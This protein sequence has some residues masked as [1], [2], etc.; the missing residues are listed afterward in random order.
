[1]SYLEVAEVPPLRNPVLV[2]AFGGWNDAGQAATS[3]VRFLIEAWSPQRF[4]SIDPEEFFDFTSA[5]PT[6]RLAPGRQREI[7]WP[8]NAFFYKADSAL[9]RDFVL[10]LGTEPH[11]KWRAF[12]GAVVQVAQQCGVTLAI[13]LGA[14]LSE[15]PH[16]RS[17]PLTGFATDSGLAAK[18]E[19]LH[20]VPTR[21]EGPTGIVGTIHDACRRQGLSAASLWAAVP[22]YLGTMENPKGAATLLHSLDILLDLGLDIRGLERAVAGFEREVAKAIASNPE[23][24]AYVQELE[25]RSDALS[26]EEAAAGAGGAGLPSGDIL[27]E[28]LEDFLKGRREGEQED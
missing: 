2:M 26:E 27:I 23:I 4:A 5:R 25:R 18:L 8:S 6:I 16:S 10:L 3:A 9:S 17:V 22:H 24:A 14:L 11:L 21:Y 19:E 15:T 7:E 12:A 1:M 28:E 20:I 13:G